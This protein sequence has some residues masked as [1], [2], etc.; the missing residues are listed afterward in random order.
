MKRLTKSTS[1]LLGE[2]SQDKTD[3]YLRVE[4]SQDFRFLFS[5]RRCLHRTKPPLLPRMVDLFAGMSYYR[6]CII[7]RSKTSRQGVRK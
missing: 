5:F 2:W 1:Y 3:W 7:T 4:G 6:P